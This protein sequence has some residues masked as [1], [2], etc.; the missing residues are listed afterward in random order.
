MD[1]DTLEK[2][3]AAMPPARRAALDAP[4]RGGWA[5]VV[6][7][8]LYEVPE[9]NW[10]RHQEL[11]R[12]LDAAAATQVRQGARIHLLA[13]W[14]GDGVRHVLWVNWFPRAE[15][16]LMGGATAEEQ[17]LLEEWLGL[18][19]NRIWHVGEDLTSQ[20]A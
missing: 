15:F 20:V 7:I 19:R 6:G 11:V 9:E 10:E 13:A 8:N 3:L 17:A 5:P 1:Q 18:I 12:L 16:F 2:A 4:L 14:P